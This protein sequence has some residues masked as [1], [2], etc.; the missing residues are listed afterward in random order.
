[1]TTSPVSDLTES[2][3]ARRVTAWLEARRTVHRQRRELAQC[4]S[5]LDALARDVGMSS[6]S[7]L[8][9]MIGRG[10]G[11][12]DLLSD[13]AATLGIPLDALQQRDAGLVRALQINC[14]RCGDKGRCHRELAE[15]TAALTY[16]A[17]CPNADTLE[18][19]GR[20][21]PGQRN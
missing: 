10:P 4:G 14:S 16:H 18:P 20:P 1:M 19:L 5:D 17:F 9:D 2:G 8:V 12:S 13:M 6:P 11:S 7:E 15:D 3:L 21:A